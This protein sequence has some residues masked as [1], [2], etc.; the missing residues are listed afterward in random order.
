VCVCVCVCVCVRI[1]PTLTQFVRVAPTRST[2]YSTGHIL[3]SYVC[4][5]CAYDRI[6]VVGVYNILS[7]RI[8]NSLVALTQRTRLGLYLY[9]LYACAPRA[10]TYTGQEL[11]SES[12]LRTILCVCVG[13]SAVLLLFFSSRLYDHYRFQF[14]AVIPTV[15]VVILLL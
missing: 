5:V 2:T 1:P 15:F 13:K 14:L 7:G 10:H 11:L 4:A 3:L 12:P 6:S 8:T 9:V